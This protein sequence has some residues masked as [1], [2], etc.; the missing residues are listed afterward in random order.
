MP[1]KVY[2]GKLPA[3]NLFSNVFLKNCII[4]QIQQNGN[5]SKWFYMGREAGE[6]DFAS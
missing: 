6:N 4:K 1:A 3:C 2:G 5:W